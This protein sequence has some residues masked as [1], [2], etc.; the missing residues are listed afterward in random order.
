MRTPP[1][2][3]LLGSGCQGSRNAIGSPDRAEGS[4]QS[5]KKK[6]HRSPKNG[7]RSPVTGCRV[8]SK[9][10]LVRTAQDR[11]VETACVL[12]SPWPSANAPKAL[13]LPETKFP[14]C[15]CALGKRG[16]VGGGNMRVKQ[17]SLS[18][19]ALSQSTDSSF[20]EQGRKA[21][22]YPKPGCWGRKKKKTDQVA[23]VELNG[24]RSL[25]TCEPW[26]A[27][28]CVRPTLVG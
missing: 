21:L 19:W 22:F 6:R 20:S 5:G 25:E 26:R 27:V 7:L 8:A 14:G 11:G 12:C 4:H 2:L 28:D 23:Q 24:V 13:N 17:R 1:S 9:R 16:W 10:K 18:S 15:V 3:D